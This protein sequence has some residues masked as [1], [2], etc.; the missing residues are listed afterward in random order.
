MRGDM[1]LVI[2]GGA[3]VKGMAL[4]KA[5]RKLVRTN[6]T[7]R[8]TRLN[9]VDIMRCDVLRNH[10]A[11]HSIMDVI[12]E[13]V[14]SDSAESEIEVSDWFG[15]HT[16]VDRECRGRRRSIRTWLKST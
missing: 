6:M 11:V 8:L 16:P 7:T 15:R 5:C 4:D 1:G 12:F 13:P 10:L 3:A 14:G 9:W 2:V